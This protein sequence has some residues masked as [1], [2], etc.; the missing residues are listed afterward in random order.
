MEVASLWRHPIKSIG[1][2]ALDR[3]AL[4]PA[5]ALPWDRR[6]AVTHERAKPQDGGWAN[7]VNFLRGVAGPALMAVTARLD[8]RAGRVTLRHPDRPDLDV[9]PVAE[10]P[11]LLA[12]LDPL[13]PGDQPRPA[14]VVARE[15]GYADVPD[16][17]IAINGH[18][19]HRAVEAA[20]DRPLS[21]HRW[22]GNVW[23]E[24]LEAWD[25]LDLVGRRVGLGR[26]V[27]AIREPIGRCK[28]TT[29]DPETG[30]RDLD[31]LAL[32]R[33][34]WGHQD[35]GVYAEVVEGGTVSVGDPVRVL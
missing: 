6:W 8:E 5:R 16:P 2:E 9:D 1:R 35:F 4:A 20:A 3:A 10:A 26:A 33:A 22:R 18:A 14:G 21:I 32:L 31:T 12:W 28:A 30:R 29:A 24:G 23:I 27:L 19:S 15:A 34:G 25:E 11:A 17:W 7:K 13:W